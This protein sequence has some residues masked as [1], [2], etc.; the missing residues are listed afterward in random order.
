MQD[1]SGFLDYFFSD[2]APQLRWGDTMWSQKANVF[3]E[4]VMR[5][6]GHRR[7]EKKAGRFASALKKEAQM[8]QD[9]YDRKLLSSQTSSEAYHYVVNSDDE[10]EGRCRP[11][12]WRFRSVVTKANKET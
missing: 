12:Y 2:D 10:R 7:Y 1:T 3:A 4:Y 6:M 9:A 8:T 5:E 11:A